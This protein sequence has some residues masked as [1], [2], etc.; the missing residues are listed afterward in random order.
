MTKLYYQDEKHVA[1]FE[2]GEGLTLPCEVNITLGAGHV[3]GEVADSVK[4]YPSVEAALQAVVD[5]IADGLNEDETHRINDLLAAR[6]WVK[7]RIRT[8]YH[9]QVLPVVTDPDKRLLSFRTSL[10]ECNLFEDCYVWSV[11]KSD[12]TFLY[13][14]GTRLSKCEKGVSGNRWKKAIKAFYA[15]VSGDELRGSVAD[16]YTVPDANGH[17]D[18]FSVTAERMEFL[19]GCYVTTH[20]LKV[21]RF[22]TNGRKARFVN[23][24]LSDDAIIAK[25]KTNK[26]G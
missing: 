12:V 23:V 22:D 24:L 14:Y 3:V 20:N 13:D 18:G 7:A 10:R 4:V 8:V 1:F 6:D 5:G 17:F 9:G 25:K 15:G 19:R 11:L 21:D 16:G 26:K 2:I